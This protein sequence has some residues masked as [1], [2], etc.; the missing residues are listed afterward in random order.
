VSGV[1]LYAIDSEGEWHSC[2]GKFSFKDTITYSF[3][4]L[5]RN[6][7]YHKLGREYRLFLPLYNTVRDLE[8]GVPDSCIFKPLPKMREKPI[9]VYG[10]SIAQGACAS[11]PAMGWTNI[12]S[13]HF[14]R[15]V[16]NLAFSGNGQ[17]E[18]ELIDFINEIDA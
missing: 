15:P 18:K 3:E 8:I 9:V 7:N 2:A 12:I 11:R 14:D 16:I 17:L 5:K 4:K 13:R 10:T 1:D 6:D